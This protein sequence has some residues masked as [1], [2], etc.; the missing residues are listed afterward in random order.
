MDLIFLA[1]GLGFF[2]LTAVLVVAFEK[3][4]GRKGVNQVRCGLSLPMGTAHPSRCCPSEW[5]SLN[6]S[7][8]RLC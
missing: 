8:S 1:L 2:A 3:L 5:I 4:R 7:H 6:Y